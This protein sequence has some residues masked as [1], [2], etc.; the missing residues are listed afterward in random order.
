MTSK[1]DWAQGSAADT[2]GRIDLPMR[3]PGSGAAEQAGVETAREAVDADKIW[4]EYERGRE[5]NERVGLYETVKNNENFYIGKQWEDVVAPDL[6]KPVLNFLRRVTTY[7]LAMLTSED[8][9]VQIQPFHGDAAADMAA[10]VLAGEVSRVI[11]RTRIKTLSREMLRNCCVD[12]DGC[13]YFYFEP[14]A[15]TGQT[16]QGEIRCENIDNVKVIF[17]NPFVHE[18]QEQPYILLVQR[19][20]LEQA[21]KLAREAGADAEAIRPDSD[22]KYI[23]EESD[24]QSQLVTVLIRLWRGESGTIQCCKT[25]HD[26]ILREAWD[27]GYRLYPV[28]WMS[29]EKIKSSYHGQAALTG[30]I[31]NQIFVNKLWAMAMQHVKLSAFPKVFYDRSRIHEWTN[32]VGEA[33]GVNGN[34]NEQ[35]AVNFRQADLSAQLL[36]LVDRT[37]NYTKEFMGASD[38]ALGNVRPENTSAIIAVQKANAV[39]LELQRLAYYQF[40]EDYI[41]I[42]ID[43]MRADYGVRRVMADMDGSGVKQAVTLDFG[44]INADALELNIDIGSSAYWSE[45]TQIQTLDNLFNK[46]IISDA[47]TYLDAMPDKYVPGKQKIIEQLK[48][49]QQAQ[50]ALAQQQMMT[51]Q[52]VSGQQAMI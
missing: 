18:V 25:T 37:V 24:A 6:E 33:I 34:P 43:M 10:K 52:G 51:Q 16:A 27:T 20:Q 15:Y 45:L 4:R 11:E 5:Y 41:R 49:R 42:M 39:P 8:V 50:A 46:Q 30:L 14:S 29:W 22:S 26:V 19:L 13:F 9:G 47:V 23:N 35:I 17:G 40:C 48:A 38:A 2:G 44:T 1:F 31:P 12:G 36:E 32:R 7:F 21:R 3:M 28:A